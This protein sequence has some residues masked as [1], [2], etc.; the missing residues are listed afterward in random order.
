MNICMLAYSFYENDNRMRRYAEALSCRGDKVDVV[1]LNHKGFKSFD[2]LNGVNVYRIQNRTVDEKGPFSYF[3]KLFLFLLNS[4]FFIT[5]L[6]LFKNRYDVIHVH[7]VPDSEVFATIIPKMLGAKIILDIHDIVPELYAS[8]FGKGKDSWVFKVLHFIEKI[9]IMFSDHV[10]IANHI[11]EKT[12]LSRSIKREKLSVFLNY[13]DK[14]YFVKNEN[15]KKS[16]D[17]KN[18]IK[19]VYP[20]TLNWHQGLDVA[21]KAI[22]KIKNYPTKIELHIY[23]NGKEKQNLIN[24][25]NSLNLSDIVFFKEPVSLENVPKILLDAD[26]GIV[27]KRKEDSFGNEAFST[28]ILEFMSLGIPVVV[29]DTKIDKFYFKDDQVQFFKSGDVDDLAEKLLLLIDNKGLR[30]TLVNNSFEHLKTFNWEIHKLRY[31]EIVDKLC[32]KK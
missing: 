9:S 25:S 3:F 15:L 14:Q 27:P 17:I 2:V 18:V 24:L 26:I 31:F 23:G 30:D 4:T 6:H 8:K 22:D 5:K 7:S 13:P 10:I 16:E 21:I 1:A 29:S 19:V 12:L 32:E 28:K 11:W 20:G